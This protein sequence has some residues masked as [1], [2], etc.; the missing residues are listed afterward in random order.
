MSLIFVPGITKWITSI[1]WSRRPPK[2]Q[3]FVDNTIST[4]RGEP[5]RVLVDPIIIII[6]IIII[7]N[8]NNNNGTTTSADSAGDASLIIC[9]LAWTKPPLRHHDPA[10][11]PSSLQKVVAWMRNREGIVVATERRSLQVGT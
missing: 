10:P 3:L 6:I 1:S 4:S 11:E 8:N 5:Y 2:A 7:I 9:K